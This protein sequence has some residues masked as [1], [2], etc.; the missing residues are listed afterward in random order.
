MNVGHR[1]KAFRERLGMSQQE[2]ADATG[3]RQATI[4]LIESGVNKPQLHTIQLIA[5]AI[6]A[7]AA[8]LLSTTGES[9]DDFVSKSLSEVPGA[10]AYELTRE[11][12]IIAMSTAGQAH[13]FYG[14][15]VV[16]QITVPVHLPKHIQKAVG[17]RIVGDS[18]EPRYYEGQVVIVTNDRKPINGEHVVANIKNMGPVFKQ[19]HCNGDPQNTIITL[20]SHNP[21]YEP[22]KLKEDDLYWIYPV[23]QLIDP[24]GRF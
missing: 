17:I 16:H 8:E 4:S 2:L 1:V 23:I 6:G 20:R 13:D 18:M 9:L 11:V 19:F 24:M 10:Y 15:P 21:A 12:P 3:L 22:I 5:K 7:E 14:I